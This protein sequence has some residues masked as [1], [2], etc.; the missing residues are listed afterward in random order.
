M[1]KT[2]RSE[3][4]FIFFGT[5]DIAVGVLDELEKAD[6][7]P[8]LIVT[9]PDKPAGRGKTMTPPP[10]KHWALTH[11]IETLQPEKLDADFIASLQS[12]TAALDVRVFA[13]VDYGAFLPKK[14]LNIPARGV[15]NM[16]PSLLPRLRG[17]SPIRSAL[18][19]DARETGVTVMLV[20][21]KMDH[22]PVVAQRKVTVPNWPPRGRELDALLSREGGK[23]LAEILP[24]WVRD[25][26]ESH[27]QNH[28]V[29]TYSTLF[30][31]EDGALDLVNGDPYK[32]LLKIRA[33][34]GWP[35]TYSF[36]EKNG[37]RIRVQI[38]DAH[39]ENGKLVPDTV[40]P[41]GK[42]EMPYRDFAHSGARPIS[43]STL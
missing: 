26:I 2:P 31:K 8:A 36:F 40:K 41:E 33:F 38:L 24:L 10:A 15:L 43:L 20:D 17:P 34:D 6:K 29:A 22:G 28:D 11:D 13:V 14:L 23:L 27:E 9:A 30:K 39:I 7:L 37:E 16:H 19:E 32:N 21:E 35:G 25:D 12:K 18:L 5:G 42:K 4:P 1:T 3:T